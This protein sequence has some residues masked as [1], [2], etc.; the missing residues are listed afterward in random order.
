MNDLAV[1]SQTLDQAVLSL[2]ISNNLDQT[3][4]A[5]S[6]LES[7][8]IDHPTT[9]NVQHYLNILE[10]SLKLNLVNICQALFIKLS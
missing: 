5:N 2:Q 10:T 8:F 1:E 7:F 4:E 9:E 6:I 3:L